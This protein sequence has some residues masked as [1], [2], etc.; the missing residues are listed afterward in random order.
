M[1][2]S[3]V[4]VGLN[5]IDGLK[6][7]MPSV[8]RELFHQI[9]LL[10]GQSIDGSPEWAKDQG[11]DVYIQK[12]KGIRKA[13]SEGWPYIT[14]DYVITFSPDGNCKVDDIVKIVDELKTGNYDMVIASR[15]KGGIKSEDD[16]AITAFGNWMFTTLI[17]LFYG[18]SYTDSFC[19]FRGYKKALYYELELHKESGYFA[20]RLFFTITGVE[21]L[22][23][24]R[25][26]KAKKKVFEIPSIEPKRIYG[27]RKLQIIRWGSAYLSQV[28]IELF[29]WKPKQE[30]KN[31]ISESDLIIGVESKSGN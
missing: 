27:V 2:I 26:A 23:S 3:L 7:L 22:L 11:Y 8:P 17:N 10:D 4:I 31:G 12:E 16:S 24:I 21:P 25:A 30:T 5:E 9:I 13:Y 20:D 1:K 6:A 14:G 18:G 15:Y 28:F 19:I 29:F